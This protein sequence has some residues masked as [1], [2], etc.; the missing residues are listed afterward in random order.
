MSRGLL[1]QLNDKSAMIAG[2]AWQVSETFNC[3]GINSFASK[4]LCVRHNAA[5]SFLDGSV[6]RLSQTLEDFDNALAAETAAS[7][8]ELR[9][10]SG[11]DIERW[12]LKA[13]IGGVESKNLTSVLHGNL[14]DILFGI[15][16]WPVNWGLYLETRSGNP[17]YHS[18]SFRLETLIDA[19]KIIKG[20]RFIIRGLPL[21][22]ALGEPDDQKTFI[23][24]PRRIVL[25]RGSAKRFIELS[26]TDANYTAW[27][28][29]DRSGGYLGYPPDWADWEK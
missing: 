14:V 24:R 11:E 22:L 12:I 27:V 2:L 4:V 7:N 1:T 18:D 20:V 8:T 16:P 13:I 10:F 15:Q 23:Y 26:W 28:R 3:I 25:V 6:I 29:L 5:L 21:L 19:S 9:L 17:I